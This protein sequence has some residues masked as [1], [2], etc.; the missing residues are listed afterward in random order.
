MHACNADDHDGDTDTVVTIAMSHST[1]RKR[2]E[3]RSPNSDAQIPLLR[4][5]RA[6]PSQ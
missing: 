5:P 1:V 4:C 2:I 3:Y 6:L